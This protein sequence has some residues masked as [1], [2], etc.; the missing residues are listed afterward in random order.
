M[1]RTRAEARELP[2]VGSVR[3]VE[4][5]SGETL[6]AEVI[7]VSDGPPAKFYVH[8]VAHDRRMDEWITAEQLCCEEVVTAPKRPK[9]DEDDGQQELA[10]AA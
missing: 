1:P 6:V 4:R 5:R 8:Y 9:V 10:D 3:R 2:T 7:E